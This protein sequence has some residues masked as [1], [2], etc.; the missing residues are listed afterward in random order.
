MIVVL[1]QRAMNGL[2]IDR[3]W[4]STLLRA[5]STA[6]VI[7]AGLGLDVEVDSRLQEVDAG[8]WTGLTRAEI[9]AD[10]PGY[11]AEYRPRRPVSRPTSTSS[12]GRSKRSA[13]SPP[14]PV[15]K[16]CWS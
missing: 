4:A 9:D 7:A 15:T 14:W 2:S 10:W 12:H 11:L 16:R 5:C 3:I 8:E 1:Q 6:E 13:T